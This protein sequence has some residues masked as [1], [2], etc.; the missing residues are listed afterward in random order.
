MKI[1]REFL[2]ATTGKPLP[3]PE[4]GPIAFAKGDCVA[5]RLVLDTEIPGLDQ[6]VVSDLLP[7]GLEIENPR[8]ATSAQAPEWVRDQM[9]SASWVMRSDIR[10]DRLLLFTGTLHSTGPR[11]YIY[12]A[13]AVTTG[14]YVLPA[15]EAEAMYDPTVRARGVPTKV[16]VRP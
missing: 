14:E 11:M 6:V 9:N 1:S 13:R 15:V 5:V 10:D 4:N 16:E 12:L 8:L 2:D 7:A 3:V